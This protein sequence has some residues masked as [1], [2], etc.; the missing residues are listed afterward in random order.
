MGRTIQCGFTYWISPQ[1]SLQ[2]TYKHNSVSPDFIP[3]GGFW[4]DY[5][6]KSETY[7]RSGL[8]LKS[9]LQY[10]H[11][12]R[13]PLLFNGPQKNVTAVVELRFTLRDKK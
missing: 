4:Q 8:Y 6:V 3:Q 12:S 1:N 9:Q 7:L 5:T 10:E 13:Y 2:F 11:I